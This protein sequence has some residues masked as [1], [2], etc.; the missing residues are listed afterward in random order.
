MCLLARRLIWVI[1]TV[2]MMAIPIAIG[3]LLLMVPWLKV[4]MPLIRLL[5]LSLLSLAI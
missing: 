4:P 1:A 2:L 3:F 5:R